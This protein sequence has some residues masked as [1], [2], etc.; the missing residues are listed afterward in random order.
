MYYNCPNREHDFLIFYE[1]EKQNIFG[2]LI[3]SIDDDNGEFYYAGDGFGWD[4]GKCS[5]A[6]I[7]NGKLTFK[8]HQE[9][10][11]WS[12]WHDDEGAMSFINGYR[13]FINDEVDIF[14]IING[15]IRS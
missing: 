9:N 6:K 15:N 2:W 1:E 5:I 3:Q 8:H 14:T 11:E 4:K 10:R 13:R 7:K 12:S